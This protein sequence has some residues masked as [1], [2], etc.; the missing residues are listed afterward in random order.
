MVSHLIGVDIGTSGLKT[1]LVHAEAGVLAVAERSYPL[2]RPATAW[3]ENDPEDWYRA[4]VDTV[5]EIVARAGVPPATVLALCIVA[6]RDQFVLLDGAGRVLTPAIHWTDRRD[7]EETE[8]LYAQLGRERLIHIT[9]VIPIPGLGLPNLV[10]TKRHLPDIWRQVRWA[11]PIKDY[12]AYRLTGDIGTDVS[13]TSRSVL[14][15]WRR[16]DWSDEICAEV[17]IPREI[18]PPVRYRPSEA[19]AEL[20]S[21]AAAT[22]GLA[23]GTILAAGGGDDQAA[24]LACGVIDVGD[25][26]I[27]TGTSTCWRTVT[28]HGSEDERGLA[29]YSPHVVPGRFIAEVTIAG[30]GTSLRWF[31]DVFGFSE[32]RPETHSS[33]EE[34]LTEAEAIEPGAEGLLFYPYLDGSRLP[35]YDEEIRGVFFGI[36]PGHRR[37]HFVRSIMEGIAYSYPPLI[38]ILTDSGLPVGKLTIVD[39]EARSRAWNALKAH[40]TGRE[41]HTTGVVEAAAVGAAILAGMA[42]GIFRT[43]ADGVAALATPGDIYV[44]DPALHARYQTLRERWEAVRPHL[45]AAAH[46]SIP[47]GPRLTP[48]AL[49]GDRS[50]TSKEDTPCQNDLT[51]LPGPHAGLAGA[52]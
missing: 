7:P 23:P 30:A 51:T 37:A 28:D 33:Y 2:H 3:A 16:M 36:I 12:L 13:S 8:R 1:A 38:D 22:L 29:D 49:S 24:T 18:L 4:L 5:H 14:N 52:T 27:G 31:R 34:L 6:Q 9:G 45:F 40:V 20:D 19:R 48:D 50:A 15:D 35:Y 32:T 42:C 17:G 47:S 44:P 21:Y 25:V 39:G 26:S 11:L 10:W 43:A 46:A 41:I